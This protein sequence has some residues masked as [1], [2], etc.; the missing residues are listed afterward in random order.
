MALSPFVLRP[1]PHAASVLFGIHSD[2][3]K[4]LA[5]CSPSFVDL[6]IYFSKK[7]TIKF[8]P[9]S[10]TALLYYGSSYSTG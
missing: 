3:S 1:G 10:A 9:R 5:L 6:K 8:L 7:L 4:E 2:H